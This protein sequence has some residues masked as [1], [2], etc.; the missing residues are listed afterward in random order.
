ML[1][2]FI[3]K[4][5]DRL[6]YTIITK[7][8]YTELRGGEGFITLY[9]KCKPFTM[10]PPG[11][12]LALYKALEYIAE[13][14][15]EG[16]IVECGVWRGGQSMMAAH[17]FEGAGDTERTLWL[18]ETFA[19]MSEP[20]E[21]DM[22]AKAGISADAEWKEAQRD[23]HND[24]CYAPLED[25]QRNMQ[26]TGYPEEKIRYV[27]G[28]VE[29]TIPATLPSKIAL[30]RLDTDWYESTKHE[31]THLFPLLVEGGVLV[32]DDYQF[33]AGAKK[34]VDEYLV[35]HKVRIALLDVNGGKFGVKLC[36]Q[37]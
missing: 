34:A 1:K 10:V 32:I 12:S 17:V 3:K 16:D 2:N 21:L 8:A 25:V 19:G 15:I 27:Q 30:L 18:Y 7:R 37:P 26:S 31:L 33:W 4:L 6:G 23:T 13:A 24:W 36:Q 9:E 5:L 35:E 14:K 28:K 29:D 22:Q 20:T 11:R